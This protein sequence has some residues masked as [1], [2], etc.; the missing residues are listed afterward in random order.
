MS[1]PLH[2]HPSVKKFLRSVADAGLTIEERKGA[3]F[4]I[5]H[6]NGVDMYIYHKGSSGV[7]PATRALN[8]WEGVSIPFHK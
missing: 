7:L 8:K 4:I 3:T 6:W 2:S 1:R 5:K